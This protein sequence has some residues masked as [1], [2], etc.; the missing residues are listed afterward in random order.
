MMS[1]RKSMTPTSILRIRPQL[2]YSIATRPTLKKGARRTFGRRLQFNHNRDLASDDA[3]LRVS[4]LPPSEGHFATLFLPASGRRKFVANRLCRLG[5]Y[6]FL[7]QFAKAMRKNL[8]ESRET[9]GL[10]RPRRRARD[11]APNGGPGC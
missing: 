3:R 5:F 1:A 6:A 11:G 8:P 4:L 10:S 9:A 7:R 2:R